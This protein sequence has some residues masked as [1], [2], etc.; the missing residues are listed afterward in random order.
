VIERQVTHLSNLVNDL[1][2]VTRITR[3]RIQLQRERVEL[4]ELVRKTVQDNGSLFDRSGVEIALELAPAPVVIDADPTRV[5]QIV[6][7]LLQNAA[8][9]SMRGGHT[10]IRVAVEGGNAVIRVADDGVGMAEETTASLFQPFMQAESTLDRSKGGLG[11]GLALVK[12]LV[13]MHGGHVATHSE[14]LGQGA[15]FVVRLPVAGDASPEKVESSEPP[16]SSGR[17]VLIIEDN[18]DSAESLR[19]VLS[20]F[21]HH[22]DVA[23]DGP[24]GIAKARELR[25]DVVLCDI[26]LPVMDGYEIARAFRADE[27]LRSTYLVALSGYTLPGDLQRAAEAGFDRHLAKP[28][29]VEKLHAV[30]SGLPR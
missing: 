25:P 7:N 8:K 15:E 26:G 12:R 22:V 14:G 24:E 9:F 23:Y 19:E 2:D 16:S 17:R 6:S 20:L 29:T 4:N 18:I 11:L 10:G 1:L 27:A 3:N 5:A 13:E 21:E 28:S 30:L